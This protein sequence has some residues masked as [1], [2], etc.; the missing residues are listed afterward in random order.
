MNGMIGNPALH[1][2]TRHSGCHGGQQA[3]VERFRNNIIIAKSDVLFTIRHVHDI[4]HGRFGQFGK[5]FH[6]REFHRFVDLRG[7]HIQRSP[8]NVGEAQYI[9]HLVGIITAAR[10]H[11]HILPGAGRVFPGDFGIG[12]GHREYDRVLRHALHHLGCYAI[13]RTQ[14]DK[15]IGILHRFGQGH[16]PL[17]VGILAFQFIEIG[18]FF[19][20]HAFPVEH[21]EVFMFGAQRFVEPAAGDGGGAGAIDHEFCF[22]DFF[23][24]QF[25]RVQ[26]GRGRDDGRTMLVVV[27]DGDLQLL[28]Q[29]FFYVKT[30]RRLDVFQVDAPECGFQG[31]DDLYEFFRVGFVDLDIEYVDIGENFKQDAFSFHDGLSG[32]RADI[33][34]P[35]YGRP[36]ADHRHQVSLGRVFINVFLVVGYFETGF[37]HAGRIG[38]GEVSLRF[39]FFGGNNFYFSGSSFGM[40]FQRLLLAK[41]VLH[42][43]YLR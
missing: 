28:L 23:L 14:P 19:M 4:R 39:G 27:H 8:E 34:K 17:C 33:A 42:N 41:I 1:G 12:I 21:E 2:G 7:A 25:Q 43:G 5:G 11:D 35:Q 26:Q 32:F 31:F 20:Q 40:V 18:P 15:H 37:C 6:G 16:G 24:L 9:V 22:F 30:F 13:A 3:R 38:E 10:G 29:F 36:V